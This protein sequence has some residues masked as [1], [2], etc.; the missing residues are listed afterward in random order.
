MEP[1][2]TAKRVAQEGALSI[3]ADL[4]LNLGGDDRVSNLIRSSTSGALETG[5]SQIPRFF[6][7]TTSGR[8]AIAALEPLAAEY[9]LDRLG[10]RLGAQTSDKDVV[11]ISKTM[12]D[13]ANPMIPIKERLA[14][15][16]EV[17]R[18]L[19]RRA[20]LEAPKLSAA[21]RGQAGETEKPAERKRIKFMELGD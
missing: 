12:G 2:G 4:D 19:A 13:I 9:S 10:G 15:W 8:E 5:A 3:I 20:N 14:A 18:R 1:I 11:F 17:K 7:A 6:G 16:G 21:P